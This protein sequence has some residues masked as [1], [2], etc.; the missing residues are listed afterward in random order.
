M[1]T[2]HLQT[3]VITAALLLALGAGCGSERS[4]DGDLPGGGVAGSPSQDEGEG[5]GD[6]GAN[7]DGSGA[8]GDGSGA[9]GDASG[10][11]GDGEDGAPPAVCEN[12]AVEECRV[13]VGWQNGVE[14]CFDGQRLC[15]GGQWTNCHR[16][17]AADTES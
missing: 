4:G 11:S 5:E 15:S 8:S 7:G 9:S 16:P 6:G 14:T 10:A 1:T 3:S 13:E 2:I 17:P 12:G